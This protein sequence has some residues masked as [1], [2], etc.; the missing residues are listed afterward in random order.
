MGYKV[1][2]AGFK[3]DKCRYREFR[4]EWIGNILIKFND[5]YKDSSSQII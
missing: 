1:L 2:L 4:P 5:T 3:K